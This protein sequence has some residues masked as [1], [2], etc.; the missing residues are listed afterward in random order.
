LS[1]INTKIAGNEIFQGKENTAINQND[2]H[3]AY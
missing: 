1:E 3:A 2:A